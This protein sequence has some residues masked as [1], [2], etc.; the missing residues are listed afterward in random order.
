MY[1]CMYVS[2]AFS[3]QSSRDYVVAM[4]FNR[5]ESRKDDRDERTW[6]DWGS[7]NWTA[8]SAQSWTQTIS[9]PPSGKSSSSQSGNPSHHVDDAPQFGTVHLRPYIDVNR[10]WVPTLR[11]EYYPFNL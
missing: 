9:A 11:F 7:C 2:A 6:K 4:A 8:E 10:S 1:V 3:V 5:W